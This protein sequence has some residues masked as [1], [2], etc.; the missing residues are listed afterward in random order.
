MINKPLWQ[1]CIEDFGGYES[2]KKAVEVADTQGFKTFNV[3]AMRSH[4]LEY[5]REHGIFEVGDKVVRLD[6]ESPHIYSIMRIEDS[7]FT[8]GRKVRHRTWGTWLECKDIRHATALE[9]KAGN[10]LP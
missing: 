5:R 6:L 1:E 9:T 4:L 8:I 7:V 3:E 2:A 10:R